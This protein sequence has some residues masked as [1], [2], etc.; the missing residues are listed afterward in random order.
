MANGSRWISTS[1]SDSD[2]GSTDVDY[3][4]HKAGSAHRE[5]KGITSGVDKLHSS[6]DTQ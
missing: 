4:P 2:T 6:G 5:G 1:V 3:F